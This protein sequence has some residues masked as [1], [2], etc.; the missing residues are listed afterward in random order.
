[1]ATH[2][3]PH[4]NLAFSKAQHAGGVFA[5]ETSDPGLTPDRGNPAGRK[6]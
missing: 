2:Q 1:M 6:P 5:M 3:E 4:G